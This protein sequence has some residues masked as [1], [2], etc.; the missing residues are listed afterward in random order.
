MPSP[1]LRREDQC[2]R[3]GDTF[4]EEADM[5]YYSAFIPILIVPILFACAPNR[6]D[7]APAPGAMAAAAGPGSGAMAT[8]AGVTVKAR[9][10]A[11]SGLPRNLEAESIPLLVEVTNSSDRPI[12]LRYN[13]VQLVAP[14]GQTFH[15]IPPFRVEGEVAQTVDAPAYVATGFRVAPY[16]SRY[17]PLYDRVTGEFVFD[18]RYYSTYVPARVQIELPTSDMIRMALP[19]GVLDA[20]GSIT[21]FLYFEDVEDLDIPQVDFTINLIDAESGEQFGTI[22]IPFVVQ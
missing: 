2:G 16:L 19:E 21:G 12:N 7:L 8:E 13:D 14:G 15:A 9:A 18:P 3:D 1:V 17:Y 4:L 11:W 5:R 22:R 6:P 10:G 20:G